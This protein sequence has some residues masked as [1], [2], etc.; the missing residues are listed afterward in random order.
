MLRFLN[1]KKQAKILWLQDLNQS[2][3]DNLSNVRRGDSRHS[4][5]KQ[6]EYLKAK[7]DETQSKIKNTRDVYKGISDFK[8]NYQPRPLVIDVKGDL[9]TDSHSILTR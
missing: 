4:R 3:V 9:L 5:N 6:K 7:I 1:H 8:S 2:N